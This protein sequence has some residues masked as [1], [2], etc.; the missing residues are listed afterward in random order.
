MDVAVFLPEHEKG[1][2]GSKLALLIHRCIE[3]ANIWLFSIDEPMPDTLPSELEAA[4]ILADDFDMLP[5]LEKI[6]KL[7]PKLQ[8]I[9][10]SRKTKYSFDSY[11]R[12]IR[13][14]LTW[15]LNKSDVHKLLTH[16]QSKR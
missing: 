15:P 12:L 6:S 3:N 13:D 11:N 2:M 5:T 16:A 7:A 4:F 8:L 10:V 9:P 1:I 14:C